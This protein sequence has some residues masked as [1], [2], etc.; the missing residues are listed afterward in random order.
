MEVRGLKVGVKQ[1]SFH[2]LIQHNRS[3]I[4]TLTKLPSSC[5]DKIICNS[6]SDASSC[7]IVFERKQIFVLLLQKS[8]DFFVEGQP[9]AQP[10]L[11]IKILATEYSSLPRIRSLAFSLVKAD[12]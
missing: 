11:A 6:E 4:F 3:W 10:P 5:L 7:W 12:F 9:V 1:K 8:T 2:S